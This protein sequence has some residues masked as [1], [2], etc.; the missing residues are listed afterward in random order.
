MS[1]RIAGRL[2]GQ[3]LRN[4]SGKNTRRLSVVKVTL[5]GV[6]LGLGSGLTYCIVALILGR[7]RGLI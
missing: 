3:P 5:I 1:T 7:L 2:A 6:T 4:R